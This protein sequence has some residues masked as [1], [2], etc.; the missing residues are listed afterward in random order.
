MKARPVLWGV[1]GIAAADGYDA[2]IPIDVVLTPAVDII[3]QQRWKNYPFPGGKVLHGIDITMTFDLGADPGDLKYNRLSKWFY[4]G[5]E[6]LYRLVVEDITDA[7]RRWYITATTL[8][9]P[10]VRGSLVTV[11]VHASDP[12]WREYNLQTTTWNVTASGQTKIITPRGNLPTPP[13]IALTIMTAKTGGYLYNAWRPFYNTTTTPMSGLWYLVATMDTATE[14]AAGRMLATGYDLRLMINNAETPRWLTGMGTATTKIWTTLPAFKG[15]SEMTLGTAIAGAGSIS[16]ITFAATAANK[17]ALLR[18][19][20]KGLVQSANGEAFAYTGINISLYQLTGVSRTARNTSIQLHA[21]NTVFRYIP[22]DMLVVWGKSTATDP[23][24]S[25]AKKPL[26]NLTS[27]SNTSWAD[28][29]FWTADGLRGGWKPGKVPPLPLGPLSNWYTGP[30]GGTASTASEMG[31]AIKAYQKPTWK[32]DKASLEWRFNCPIGITHVT[33]AGQKRR[34]HAAWPSI[35]ALQYSSDGINW[36][37]KFNE[38]APA[39]A[40]SWVSITNTGA[41]A[42][43]ATYP[44][45]RFFFSGASSSNANNA[46]YLEI[47]SVTMTLDS[48]N[49]PGGTLQARMDNYHMQTTISNAATG[50]AITID[51]QTG[52]GHTITLDCE[53]RTATLE[54]GTNVIDAISWNSVRDTWLDLVVANDLL[55]NDN[56][57]TFTDVG[58]GNVNAVITHRAFMAG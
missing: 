38:A 1:N 50:H 6:S 7:S 37:T 9:K 17:A 47:Q 27:S 33:V 36:T 56:V 14:V 29:D 53:A 45:L 8:S 44:Y 25:D 51:L 3:E 11:Q 23:A 10:R 30:N 49:V 32:A 4:P 42:L 20:K 58:T 41:Q 24:Y 26:L 48:A 12:I 21:A 2:A 35:A 13:T 52:G 55:V 16:T 5:D 43:G 34:E 31:M 40:A 15:K 28:P 46:S 57:L 19:G 18:M 39:S 22:L 54:D